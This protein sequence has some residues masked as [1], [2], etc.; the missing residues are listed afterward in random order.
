[1]CLN[2]ITAR[3]IPNR[4]FKNQLNVPESVVIGNSE[5][6]EKIGCSKTVFEGVSSGFM[7][8]KT[9]LCAST[10]IHAKSFRTEGYGELLLHEVI[11]GF[12]VCMCGFYLLALN[13][14]GHLAAIITMQGRELQDEI[15]RRILASNT[16]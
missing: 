6:N 7:S 16:K 8:Y 5:S 10:A 14:E 9:F 12:S 11:R 2:G 3:R 13:P 1:M 4:S 15:T